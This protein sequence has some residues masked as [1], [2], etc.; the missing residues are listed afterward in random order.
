MVVLWAFVIVGLVE[1]KDLLGEAAEWK[2]W[3]SQNFTWLYIAAFVRTLPP[4]SNELSTPTLPPGERVSSA[5]RQP[6]DWARRAISGVPKAA[7]QPRHVHD[8]IVQSP[9]SARAPR[10]GPNRRLLTGHE[11]GRRP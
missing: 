11:R 2:T 5:R 1:P 4:H 6:S 7:S 10:G 8:R 3:V 9:P